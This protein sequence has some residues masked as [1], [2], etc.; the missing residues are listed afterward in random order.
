LKILAAII[1]IFV[2]VG[3]LILLKKRETKPSYYPY[4]K[5]GSLFSPAERSFLGVLNQV[6]GGD[7]RILAKV[8]V[9]DVI[10]PK[11]GLS[12]SDCLNWGRAKRSG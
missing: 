3:I 4:Q 2:V 1:I 7:V 11:K 5:A 6:V 9:A 10:T 8:R 12:R